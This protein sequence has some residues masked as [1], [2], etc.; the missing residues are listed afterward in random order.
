MTKQELRNVI[1]YTNTKAGK[2]FDSFIQILIILSLVGFSIETLP[3][4]NQNVSSVLRYFEYFSVIIF[5][6]E[7]FLRVLLSVK[8]LKYIFSFYGIIDLFA[9]LPFYL[10]TTMDLRSIRVF[11]LLRLIRALKLF[12]DAKAIRT[13]RIALN[14][15]KEELLMFSSVALFTIYVS[16]VGI[17]Y[18][19][20][21]L[22]P[23]Q[24]GSIFH[25]L[26]W[27]VVTLTSVG[28]GD[29]YPITL[30]GKI[31]TSFIAIIGVAILAVPTGLMASAITRVTST[32]KN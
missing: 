24:F 31:F 4:L 13:F 27:A 26:W 22:Q 32:E 14:N 11:R 12:R 1:F 28:Y 6:L 2:V 5:S 29:V 21:E 9:I 7:Y 10:S 3:H 30:A 16:A 19:E 17:Y 23:E 18:C 8:K 20:S 15:V 25:C